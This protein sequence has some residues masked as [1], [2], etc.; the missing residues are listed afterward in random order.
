MTDQDV[1]GNKQ[2]GKDQEMHGDV[3]IGADKIIV[4][5]TG[6][7]FPAYSQSQELQRRQEDQCL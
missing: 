6:G 7:V 4:C 2:K 5:G 3:M 1:Q